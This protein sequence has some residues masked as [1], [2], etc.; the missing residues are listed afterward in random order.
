MGRI[1]V[2]IFVA[3][4]LVMTGSGIANAAVPTRIGTAGHQI[5][6]TVKEDPDDDWIPWDRVI[7]VFK[8]RQ[9]CITAGQ[10]LADAKHGQYHCQKT[11]STAWVLFK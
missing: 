9:E 6:I 8:S 11:K 4:G 1:V 5:R 10:A 3:A 2:A 7:G